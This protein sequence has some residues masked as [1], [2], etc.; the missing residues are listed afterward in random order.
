MNDTFAMSLSYRLCSD[1]I[2]DVINPNN[3]GNGG[4]NNSNSNNNN[5]N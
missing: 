5:G 2:N 3:G 1:P 4:G